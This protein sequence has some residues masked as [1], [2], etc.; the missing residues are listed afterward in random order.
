MLGYRI[1]VELQLFKYIFLSRY[2]ELKVKYERKSSTEFPALT[3][4]GLVLSVID[5]VVLGVVFEEKWKLE[6]IYQNLIF[7]K[8]V[9]M[10]TPVVKSHNVIH[11]YLYLIIEDLKLLFQP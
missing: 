8:V 4:T 1:R 10:E 3:T 9:G 6:V 7:F 2:V 11:L 5:V